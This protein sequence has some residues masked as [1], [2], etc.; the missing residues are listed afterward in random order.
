MTAEITI[1]PILNDN[2]A[3]IVFDPQTAVTG[4]IDPGEAEPVVEML[5]RVNLHLDWV[6]NTHHHW[7]HTN[8]NKA[9]IERYGA[10]WAAPKECGDADIVLNEGE[11]FYLGGIA[12][13]I[14]WTPGHTEGHVCLFC[15]QEHILFS[16]DTL[17]SMGCGRLFEGTAQD[18]F[19][20]INKIKALPAQTKIYCGHEYTLSNGEF[21]A[22]LMPD[23]ADICEQLSI[24]KTL[25]RN[26][27]PTIPFTLHTELKT[28]PFLMATSF[29]ELGD[30][31]AQKDKF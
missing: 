3:Y 14:L 12:F 19:M 13:E 10:K 15:R 17:F 23:N 30:Y 8:G 22:Y 4:V 1:V 5:D 31:R 2:Y 29:K 9:L 20:S 24:V 28:N 6:I 21:A 25:R 11:S 7:D 16:G 27:L 18:M 26:K